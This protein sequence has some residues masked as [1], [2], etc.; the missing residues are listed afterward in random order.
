MFTE[1]NT[2]NNDQT[3]K[4]KSYTVTFEV[5]KNDQYVTTVKDAELHYYGDT[6]LLNAN[7]N[8]DLGDLTCYKWVVTSLADNGGQSSEKVIT[9][10]SNEYTVRIQSDSVIKAYCSDSEQASEAVP[11]T[12][13]NQYG[14]DI[15]TLYLSPDAQITLGAKSVN[16]GN[17]TYNIQD[18]PFYEFTGWKVNDSN[19]SFDTYTVS[20]LAGE[21]K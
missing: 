9:N 10:V 1:L 11:V 17:E 5:Y 21:K 13:K 3:N 20:E 12:I 18:M 6:V 8:G 2:A 19:Y 16:T 14:R 7:E 15:Q 4:R